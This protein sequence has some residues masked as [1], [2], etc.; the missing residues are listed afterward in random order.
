MLFRSPCRWWPTSPSL[1]LPLPPPPTW[2]WAVCIKKVPQK[3]AGNA[4]GLFHGR[5]LVAGPPPKPNAGVLVGKRRRSVMR[6]LLRLRRSE[7]YAACAA[8]DRASRSR[9][10]RPRH[11][12][13]RYVLS[14]SR[15]ALESLFFSRATRCIY[16]KLT[17]ISPKSA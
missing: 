3:A 10:C 2:A 15:K 16:D 1:P 5:G 6:E 8:A 9:C 12:H 14:R 11:G 13:G 17:T 7:G 4:C